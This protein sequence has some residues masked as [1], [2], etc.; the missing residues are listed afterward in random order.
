M[1]PTSEQ[2]TGFLG[3]LRDTGPG[4]RLVWEGESPPVWARELAVGAVP[5]SAG[6]GG[7]NTGRLRIAPG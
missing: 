6:F 4:T 2:E 7:I 5:W 1:P 3:A